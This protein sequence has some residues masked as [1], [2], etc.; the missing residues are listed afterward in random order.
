VWNAKTLVRL[1]EM[2]SASRAGVETSVKRHSIVALGGLEPDQ[3]THT[4]EYK[5]M[6]LIASSQFSAMWSAAAKR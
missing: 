4:A 3:G 5:F 2:V 6:L 1:K